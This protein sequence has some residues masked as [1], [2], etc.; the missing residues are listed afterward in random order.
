MPE[1]TVSRLL[2]AAPQG[3]AAK[4]TGILAT[5]GIVPAA[6]YHTGGEALA[7][8]TQALVLTC[9]RLEDMTGPELA[10]KLPSLGVM[11]IVPGDYDPQ[12][13]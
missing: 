8:Q 11:M 9:W 4:L 6:V 1:M 3:V 13:L 12:E 5:A 7:A 10:K 2:I